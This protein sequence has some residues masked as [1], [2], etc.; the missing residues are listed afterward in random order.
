[1]SHDQSTHSPLQTISDLISAESVDRFR[2][3]E[4]HAI[5]ELLGAHPTQVIVDG[6]PVSGVRFAV[7]AP[8]A[9]R[10]CVIGDFNHWDRDA[11]LL[12]P[13]P[14][15]GGLESGIRAV[16]VPHAQPG[17]LYQYAM[18]GP[19]GE[20]L[21]YRADPVAFSAEVAPKR[22][23]RICA[24]LN[25]SWGDVEWMQSREARHRLDQP[26]SIYELHLGSWSARGRLNYRDLAAELIPYVSALGF[27]HIEVMPI[28]EYP[29]DGSW[30][31]QTLG[32]FAPTSRYGTPEDLC[33]FID[34]CHQAG[35]GVI[36][37][38]VPGHFPLDEHGLARF[39]GTCLYEH[40]DPRRGMHPD[41]GTCLYQ[42]GRYEVR[43]FLI[44]SALFWLERFHFDG[45]RVDAVASMLYL[46]YSREDGE[47]IPNH[48]G[49]NTHFEAVD[50]LKRLNEEVYGRFP[51]ALMIAEE[52]TAWPGV[53]APTYDG[54]LG[55]GRKWNMGW[56][57]DTLRYIEEDPVHRK[58]HHHLMTFGLVYQY[59]ERFILPI[60]HDEV[61]HGKGSLINKM[62]GDDWQRFANL[63]L[64]LSFMWTHP[65]QKLLFMGAEL[66]QSVEWSPERGLEW[67]ALDS[68]TIDVEGKQWGWREVLGVDIETLSIPEERAYA[69]D[70]LRLGVWLLLRRLNGLYRSVPALSQRDM[71]P[72]GFRWLLA[73]DAERSVISY[74]R[75]ADGD[76]AVVILNC[77]PVPRLGE[78]VGVPERGE[79]WEVLLNSDARC[80]A[81]SGVGVRRGDTLY[82]ESAAWQ[83][84]P[85]SLYLD[86]PPLGVVI[87]RSNTL[88]EGDRG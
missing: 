7:W 62:P 79:S 11:H 34:Q 65:G 14:V 44:S 38:W 15:I 28:T 68:E 33:V 23:S 87:L 32:L 20:E 76:D 53:S 17:Q 81:G 37:D 36:L 27:T 80:Y 83:G 22:A 30:G 26:M 35:L 47:W 77:T 71:E 29:F 55:F 59:S 6:E 54:G 61:V 88:R 13:P 1:M 72:E 69:H 57:N 50:F 73:D 40:E 86:L 67:W 63:R 49:G 82:S 21:P 10:V 5:Y 75:S 18:R 2:R 3:G 64:Y 52:S 25:H 42:Y 84:M 41:W 58:Y 8:N 60:S 85:R 51:G 12:S 43:D 78:R 70:H 46:D 45:L 74:L 56:M 39:D 9:S 4:H 24:P 48:E 16:F 66:S 31:Y 19:N